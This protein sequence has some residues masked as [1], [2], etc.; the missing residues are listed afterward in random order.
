[1]FVIGVLIYVIFEEDMFVV[2]DGL[3]LGDNIEVVLVLFEK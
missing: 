3:I 1:M 2:I